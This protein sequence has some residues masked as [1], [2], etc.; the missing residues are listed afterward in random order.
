A[1]CIL[2][3]GGLRP[4]PL[5]LATGRNILDLYATESRSVLD[6]WLARI[7]PL[8]HVPVRVVHGGGMPAPMTP[9]RAAWPEFSV[10]REPREFRGPAGVVRDLCEEH[11]AASTAPVGG[12]PRFVS[13]DIAEL[14]REHRRRN[15]DATVAMNADGS[16]SGVFAMRRSS[17]DLVGRMGFVD[18]KEQW[19]SKVIASGGVVLAHELRGNGAMPL[20]TR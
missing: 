15:A 2:L 5:V 11:P 18:L 8:G 14:V 16:P 20:R 13:C 6:V 3:A 10:E 1:A 7:E 4:S 19:L 12:A 17:L 9:P